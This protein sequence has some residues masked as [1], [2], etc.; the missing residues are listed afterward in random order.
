MISTETGR[1]GGL[2]HPLEFPPPCLTPRTHPVSRR[3]RPAPSQT[4]R[5]MTRRRGAAAGAAAAAR[6]RAE[7]A[8]RR[9]TRSSGRGFADSR[10]YIPPP[11]HPYS[12]THTPVL[13][14]VWFLR[15]LTGG[16][17]LSVRR[18]AHFGAG[19]AENGPAVIACCIGQPRC[20]P[21][22]IHYPRCQALESIELYE[23]WNTEL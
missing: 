7:R 18:R 11:S 6:A 2:L 20:R 23:C 1:R 10:G 19:H 4:P 15:C 17:L 14:K 3:L 9:R 22:R 5:A 8:G 13:D 12:H 16:R 21:Y